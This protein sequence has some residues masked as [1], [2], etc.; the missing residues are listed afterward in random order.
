MLHQSM[1]LTDL[2]T[3]LSNDHLPAYCGGS[4]GVAPEHGFDR[5][6]DVT[7]ALTTYLLTAVDQLVLHQSMVLTDLMTLLSH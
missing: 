2:M 6:D 1:V 3:L 5:S 4:V 7:V